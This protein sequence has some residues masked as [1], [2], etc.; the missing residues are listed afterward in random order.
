MLNIYIPSAVKSGF[1]YC[2]TCYFRDGMNQMWILKKPVKICPSPAIA[3]HIEL[4]YPLNN[5]SLLKDRLGEF[6]KLRFT[7]KNIQRSYKYLVLGRGRSYFVKKKIKK[8]SSK[9][10]S[11]TDIKM[12]EFSIDNTFA[13]W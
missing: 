8:N 7:R 1:S 3:L 10:F 6:V 12:L 11:E 5:Y 4:F 13:V 9:K 2:D